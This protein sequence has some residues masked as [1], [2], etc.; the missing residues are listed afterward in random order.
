MRPAPGVWVTSN[1]ELVAPIAEGA[2]GSVWVA[3]HH[4]LQTR[5]AVKF[6][7][8]RLAENTAEALARFER[9]ASTAS[10][11]KSAHVVQTFDSG[12]TIFYPSESKLLVLP[13]SA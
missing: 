8:D 3:Y 4:R 10:Q 1:I 13:E 12:I 2:M 6:V 5:V 9:E 11:I 7:S